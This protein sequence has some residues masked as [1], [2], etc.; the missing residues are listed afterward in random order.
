[1]TSKVVGYL[2]QQI[3]SLRADRV[4]Y[5]VSNRKTVRLT[6]VRKNP[7]TFVLKVGPPNYIERA[8]LKKWR[9]EGTPLSSID[10]VAYFRGRKAKR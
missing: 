9:K 10:C 6:R 1:M 2:F 7:N 8:N 5:Y 4:T 3:Q